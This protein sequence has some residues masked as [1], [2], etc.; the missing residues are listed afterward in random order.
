M[1]RNR[2]LLK[3]SIA[4]ALLGA[5]FASPA[6]LAG[7]IDFEDSIL[8]TI[9]GSQSLT[10]RGYRFTAEDSPIAQYYGATGA[11]GG[12]YSG[13]QG[14]G[15]TPCPAGNASRFYVGVNDGSV[16][17]TNTERPTFRIAGLD[18][19]F[20]APLPGLEDGIWGQL[21]LTG[22]LAG[23]GS[24]ATALDF[25][26]QNADGDF[27]FKN[28]MLDAAFSNTFLNSLNISACW[29]D[30]SGA[31]VNS[32]DSPAMNYAQFAIDNLNV[33][34][35]EPTAPALLM[36]GALGMALTARRRAK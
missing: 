26:G 12:V 2:T 24:I 3:T 7:A 5:A 34:V 1:K 31:C 9:D 35:P 29:Y 19:G 27:M 4:T 30:G 21:R 25:A 6:A 28:W 17:V 22:Y 8:T 36:L 13:A 14:C 33:N 23:G 16:T 15:D 10:S 11:A 18:F 32:A 20:L